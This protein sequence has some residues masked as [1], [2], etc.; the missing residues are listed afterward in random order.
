MKNKTKKEKTDK[1]EKR[2]KDNTPEV[3]PEHFLTT[4]RTKART[5]FIM[6]ISII[7]KFIISMLIYC[8][9]TVA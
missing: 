4:V 5:I 7:S 3:K 9:I 6:H 2:K 8:L 1:G